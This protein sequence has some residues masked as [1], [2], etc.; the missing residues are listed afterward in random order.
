MPECNSRDLVVTPSLVVRRIA[1]MLSLAIKGS[2]R[3]LPLQPEESL[4]KGSRLIFGLS[5]AVEARC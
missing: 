1:E 3:L 4:N 2:L 5:V